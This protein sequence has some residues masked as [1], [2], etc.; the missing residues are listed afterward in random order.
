MVDQIPEPSRGR[1]VVLEPNATLRSA[2]LTILG[3]ESYESEAVDSLDKVLSRAGAADRTVALV[4]WQSMQG[5]LAEQQRRHLVELTQHL[6]LL[7]MVP[8]RWA[9]LLETTD[10]PTVSALIPKP[11]EADELIQKLDYVLARSVAPSAV[12]S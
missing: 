1:V 10:L 4:A 9:R 12:T 3:A 6:R 5:L 7:V 11:F 2:I 8:R